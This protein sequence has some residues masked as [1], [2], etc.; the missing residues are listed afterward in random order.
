[1]LLQIGQ[2]VRKLSF[3]AQ[4]GGPPVAVRVLHVRIP[5]STPCLER[6]AA[7]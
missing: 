1:M 7:G 4:V 6:S 5:N 3:L 2:L